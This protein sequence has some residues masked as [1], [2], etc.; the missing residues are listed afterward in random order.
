MAH[1]VGPEIT[2]R[3]FRVTL[4]GMRTFRIFT[5]IVVAGLCAAAC[6]STS[7][8]AADAVVEEPVAQQ[9][10]APQ[11]TVAEDLPIEEAPVEQAA[12]EETAVEEVPE[13]E[14]VPLTATASSEATFGDEFPDII[15]AEA[16]TDA[17]GLWRFSV[18]VSSPYDSPE[19]Y[20][21]AWRVV[22]PDGN[23]LGIRI[24]THD[25]ASEQPFTRSQSGI[26]IPD[27][28]SEVTV[29]GRDLQNGWGGGELI[30][31]IP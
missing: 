7:S 16:I 22:D 28:I 8:V 13:E 31:A 5:A 21:D 14:T 26:E 4:K 6:S 27:G 3:C 30:V 17:S 20:A 10:A 18:T 12:V 1:G 2:R 23:E 15:G 19:R 25:H 9:Q 24:L 29:Q 11:G